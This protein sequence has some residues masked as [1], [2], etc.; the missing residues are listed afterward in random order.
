MFGI[1]FTWR[2]ERTRVPRVLRMPIIVKV[3]VVGYSDILEEETTV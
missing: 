2:V 1:W 3:E